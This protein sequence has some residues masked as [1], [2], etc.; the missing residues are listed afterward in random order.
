VAAIVVASGVWLVQ[1]GDSE[2][3]KP[4][5]VGAAVFIFIAS[6]PPR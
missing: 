2:W 4:V 5:A 3:L 1:T 6:T